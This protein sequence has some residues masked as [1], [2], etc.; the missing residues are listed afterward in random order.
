VIDQA[1]ETTDRHAVIAASGATLALRGVARKLGK[2]GAVQSVEDEPESKPAQEALAEVLGTAG[3]AA[4]P[5]L[6]RFAVALHAAVT[7]A[8]KESGAAIDGQQAKLICGRTHLR[9][10]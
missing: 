9:R 4:D 7:S 10:G 8:A 5:E 6:A 3:L 2:G 1:T